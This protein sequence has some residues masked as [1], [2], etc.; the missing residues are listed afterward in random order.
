[1]TIAFVKGA[2]AKVTG[3]VDYDPAK[4]EDSKLDV[5][6]AA[7][8]IQTRDEKRDGHLKSA[9]LFD[10]EKN[11]S[12]TF[13]SSKVTK[14]GDG[15]KVEGDLTLRGV[16]KPATVNVTALSDEVTDPW[17]LKRRGATGWAKIK[18]GDFGMG[19]NMELPGVGPMVSDEVEISLDIQFTRPQ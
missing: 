15:L 4:P 17:T 18:R 19:W 8:S 3:T 16:T 13:K 14:A 9:E 11:P 12:I 7:D 1:M 10:A 2:F 6:I 5:T